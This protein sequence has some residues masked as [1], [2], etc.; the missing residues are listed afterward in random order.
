MADYNVQLKDLAGNQ[1]FPAT[2]AKVVKN[3]AGQALGGVEADAQVNVIEGVK[4]NGVAIELQD[5]IA[6]IVLPA[7]A[8]YSITKEN[9][10]EEGFAATYKLTKDGTQVGASINIPKDLVVQSGSVKECT[11]AD[12]PVAGYKPGDKYI[13]LVLANAADQHIYILVTDLIDVY[14]GSTYID[15][16]GQVV[17]LKYSELEEALKATFY[18]ETEI[19]EKVAALNAEDAKIRED[20][21]AADTA[22]R[23]EFAAADTTLK[24]EL[25]AEI[26]KKAD[27]AT[28]LAG[29]GIT[30][31]YTKDECATLFITYEII[32][33]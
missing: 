9:T 8:E 7:A 32:N 4:L 10:P 29:Y 33:D 16:T 26:A 28:T 1:L 23:G 14:T 22:I 20:F 21:A 13:D 27:K 30:D 31:A 5:K 24:S 12:S 6:D 3:N 15:I 2:N 11:Q 25:N 17:S 18:T 19:D